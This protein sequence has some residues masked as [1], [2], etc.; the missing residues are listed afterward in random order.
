MKTIKP[1]ILKEDTWHIKDNWSEDSLTMAAATALR[2]LEAQ[3]LALSWAHDM[4]AGERSP[5]ESAKAK[6][7]GLTAGEPDLRIYLMGG[8]IVHIEL[9]TLKGR[10]SEAQT[11]RH[12]RLMALGHE[13]YLVQVGTPME[14][15]LQV[16]AIAMAHVV[17]TPKHVSILLKEASK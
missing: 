3:G 6:A 1:S 4:N 14:A 17:D 16:M 9:K 5:A 8:R 2:R 11:V 7:M 12:A 15:Y 10:T 13:V